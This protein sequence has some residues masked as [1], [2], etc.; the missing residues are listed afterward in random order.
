M[1]EQVSRFKIAWQAAIL[2]GVF[3]TGFL[4]EVTSEQRLE[5]DKSDYV[6]LD[7]GVSGRGAIEAKTVK[8][9][10]AWGI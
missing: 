7:G 5:G 10:H 4:E 2:N 6:D 3:R 9:E 1:L 8:W